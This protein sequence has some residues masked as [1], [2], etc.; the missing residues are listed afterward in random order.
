VFIKKLVV[1]NFR[2]HKQT[3]IILGEG[4]NFF[5]GPNAQG[6]T[7]LLEAIFIICVGRGWR[8]N[9]D[10][11]LINFDS[12]FYKIEATTQKDF[13]EVLIEVS[14]KDGKKYIKINGVPIQK[15]SSLMGQV[16]CVF[17]SPDELKL[18][19][20]APSDR[21]RFMDIDI[22]QLDK[23]YFL[24][25][26]KYNKIL[27]QRNALLK[28]Q[29]E[30]IKSGLEIWDKSLIAVGEYLI[31]KRI[32]FLKNIEKRLQDVH[33]VF[34]NNEEIIKISYENSCGE[35]SFE[36]A[37]INAR[38]KD[39]R[40]KTTTIGPHRDDIK[41]SINTRD[42]RSFAS[43]GQQRTAALSIKLAELQFFKEITGETP[44]LLLDDVLSELDENRR[45]KLIEL[46]RGVQ[47]IITTTEKNDAEVG[48]EIFN[49]SK[50]EVILNSL[51]QKQSQ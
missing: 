10:K 9:K 17:F 26:I 7:N 38:E 50:G 25:L 3:E 27:A 42:V 4:L 45:A 30:D 28:S 33:S 34:T 18:I 24:A 11:E 14:Y 5:V 46:T 31:S 15:V 44:I 35:S 12:D 40:L 23:N 41:I 51:Q 20:E 49:I 37:L 47:C 48:A 1:Q 13:G 32:K 22:S 6:K 19:K 8:T 16:N 36:T 39:T 2:N 43:Q 29:T 21:R